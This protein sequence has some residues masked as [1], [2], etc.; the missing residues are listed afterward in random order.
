MKGPG[1]G[2][3]LSLGP[4]HEGALRLQISYDT[5][6]FKG[7]VPSQ[8]YSLLIWQCM[9]YTEIPSIVSC[10]FIPCITPHLFEALSLPPTDFRPR[11]WRN[12]G[13]LD[14]PGVSSVHWAQ[15]GQRYPFHRQLAKQ[16]GSRSQMIY[17]G[18]L[19]CPVSEREH[20]LGISHIDPL[21]QI[22]D[23]DDC[24]VSS[25]TT[26]CIIVRHTID[27]DGI[28]RPHTSSLYVPSPP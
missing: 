19:V 13:R 16:K 3:V 22:T 14:M 17:V 20:I 5:K 10:S 21:H 23:I 12:H 18:L 6:D 15:H 26:D 4:L 2:R 1:E 7:D 24:I 11:S 27:W 8:C 28:G 9:L 25:F